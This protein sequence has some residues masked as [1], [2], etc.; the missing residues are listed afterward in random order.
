MVLYQ[1]DP[2]RASMERI[3]GEDT[4]V[5]TSIRKVV[6]SSFIGT[7]IEWYDYFIYGTAAALVFPALFFPDFSELAGTLLSFSTF[8]VGFAARPLGGIIFGHYGD[9]IGR[10][11]M[12][13]T[14]LLIMGIATFLVGCLPGFDQIGIWAPVLLVVLR[15]TQGLGL[16]G[17]WGGAVLMSVEHSPPER[18]G[19]NGS[20]PQMGA[21]AG[22]VLATGVFAAVSAITGDAFEVWGWRVP[23]LL[24]IVLIVVRLFIRLRIYESP[25]FSQVRESGTEARMPIV[26][27]L[28]SYPKNVVLGVGSR[29]GI[30]AAFYILAVYSLTHISTNLGLSQNIGLLAVSIAAL[31]EVF[32]I[33]SFGSVSD[34]VGRKPVL[35]GGA[36]LLGIWMFPFFGLLNTKSAILIILATIVGLSIAH[37]AVYSSQGSF[38]AELFGTRVRYSGASFSY[39]VSGIFGGALAPII[40]TWLYPQG[41]TTLIAAYIAALCALS[42]MCYALAPETYR[43]D[44]YAEE[45]Q[46]RQLVTEQG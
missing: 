21:P 18:R 5:P 28:R 27:V 30:D 42:V 2:G 8:A 34:R 6:V 12:L 32:S 10:K 33:P 16:G 24:S 31:I 14:T 13:V 20:W 35:I 29:I 45:P 4:G 38:Y 19:L 37:A 43:K 11:A 17:E 9:R 46:E 3:G 23:F 40:A 22:L 36:A 41:G 1:E 25:A 15:L 7:T 39:Q 44:I 26:D